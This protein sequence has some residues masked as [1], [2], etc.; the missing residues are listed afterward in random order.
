MMD[1]DGGSLL[2]DVPPEYYAVEFGFAPYYCD[3]WLSP[4]TLT[5]PCAIARQTVD[6]WQRDYRGVIARLQHEHP[7]LAVF[8]PLPLLCDR[9]W[10][11]AKRN[12]LVLYRDHDHLTADGSALVAGG[13]AKVLFPP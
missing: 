1:R 4:A 3:T 8:D 11:Y 9:G 2:A 6:Q 12:G 5:N 13:L 10:C 7:Q